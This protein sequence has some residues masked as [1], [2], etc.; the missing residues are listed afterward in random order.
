MLEVIIAGAKRSDCL[1]D[2]RL[3]T[4]C[5]LGFAD[6]LRFDELINIQPGDFDIQTSMMSIRI[7]QSKTDQ[8]CQGDTAGTGVSTC[9][10]AMLGC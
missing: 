1:S 10:V 4:A 6:F 3:A 2:I 9:Q 5:L 8:L 7:A